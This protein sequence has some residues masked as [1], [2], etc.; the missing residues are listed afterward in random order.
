MGQMTGSKA[1]DSNIAGGGDLAA[2]RPLRRLDVRDHARDVAGMR[3]V[4]A[5]LSRRA[6]GL[7]VGINLN[8]N[9]ACN[10]Q[11]IYCQVPGLVRGTAPPVD[12]PLLEQ[13]LRSFLAAARAGVLFGAAGAS[14]PPRI[15]D[16]ALSGNG[17]PTSAAEFPE[18][19]GIVLR[20]LREAAFV[21]GVVPRVIT[22]GSL[23]GRARVRSG[24]AR[25]AAGG[26]EAWFKVDAGTPAGFAQINRV[27]VNPAQVARNLQRCAACCPTWVQTCLLAVDGKAPDQREIEAYL[28]LL[29][30]A[31][32]RNLRGVLLYGLAR[33]SMQP[34]AE[35]LSAL[36]QAAM[37]EI[38]GLIRR[39]G[40]EVRLSP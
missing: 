27:R 4:Y 6:G 28:R 5:V 24:L 8:P 20:L 26:G 16:V 33:Q 17:E 23:L 35:R 40:L 18:V 15:V 9:N 32:T 29:E 31:G 38:A 10:W 22:N 1:A 25:L 19:I 12:L 34:G 30:T 21:P 11:C 2:P 36:P 14:D 7:S 13:E 37:E 3:Y 39:L